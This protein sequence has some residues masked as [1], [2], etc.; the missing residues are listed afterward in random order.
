MAK[1]LSIVSHYYNHPQMVENQ[2]A[3]WDSLPANLLEKIE[4][5]LIDDCS[6]DRPKIAFE[7]ADIK[8]FRVISDIAWNQSGCRNLG[9][10]V[11]TSEWALFADIDQR[12]VP[13][14]IDN[15]IQNLPLLNKSLMYHMKIKELINI[16][17]GNSLEFA[18]STFLVHLP[19]YKVL[20]RYD[21]D[22]AGHYGYEDL[23]AQRV[24]ECNGGKR[25]L[26]NNTVYFEDLGFGTT[27]LDRDISR[28]DIL[29]QQK[30]IDGCNNAPTIL[31]FE[32]EQVDIGR[33][34]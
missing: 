25:T 13:W 4:F 14:P 32:W 16:L 17:S 9:S 27:T 15:L 28:N 11:A 1:P 30:L 2:V 8:L 26:L 31:R 10:F 3:Y 6:E 22:F 21:E 33:S 34:N 12:F 23:Y 29:S 20:G 18:P 7:R 5:I 24:W 19:T